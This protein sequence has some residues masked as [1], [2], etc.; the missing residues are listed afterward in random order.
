ME[1]HI[2]VVEDDAE[3]REGVAIYLKNQ[4]Y[5]VPVSYTHLDVYKRQGH[6][7]GPAPA[8]PLQGG[9]RDTLRWGTPVSY[10]HLDVY[11][12]Q[13]HRQLL[14]I[15]KVQLVHFVQHGDILQKLYLMAL[16]HSLDLIPVSY[17]HLDVYKRQ[18]RGHP[19]CP[20]RC[21]RQKPGWHQNP[22]SDHGDVKCQNA[23]G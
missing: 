20:W 13:V 8:R 9:S 22:S 7:R 1:T 2:L 3:I 14:E 12:R 18:A 21:D 15:H 11:K 23:S 19:L 16:Q 17:T 6:S 5:T 10:T 4:G